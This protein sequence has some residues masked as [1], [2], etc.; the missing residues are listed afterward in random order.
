MAGY[1]APGDR[2]INATTTNNQMDDQRRAYQSRVVNSGSERGI[3]RSTTPLFRMPTDIFEASTNV[4]RGL[5]LLA[6]QGNPDFP[7]G[8]AQASF[9]SISMFGDVENQSDL[10]NQKGPNLIAPDINDTTFENNDQQ[11]SQFTE[12]GFGWRD[13]RND[14]GTETARIGQYFSK[15]YSVQG[16]SDDSP[17]FGEAKSPESD[18]NIDYDQP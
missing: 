1:R 6:Q 14:P 11:T 4:F 9:A 5:D 16:P 15:H 18:P 8:A 10:P 13:P 3:A 17:I 7:L 12:R 2:F